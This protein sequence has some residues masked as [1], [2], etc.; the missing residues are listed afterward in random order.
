MTRTTRILSLPV[1]L[2]LLLGMALGF[3]VR[4]LALPSRGEPGGRASRPPARLATEAPAASVLDW[5]KSYPQHQP[6]GKVLQSCPDLK[7]GDP[8]PQDLSIFG[9]AGK[10]SYATVDDVRDFEEFCRMCAANKP[11]FRAG[12]RFARI[13]DPRGRNYKKLPP[14]LDNAANVI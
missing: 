1:A 4:D 3:V 2:C 5:E 7:P 6:V 8:C 10:T 11:K 14:A 9:G 13:S 12:F